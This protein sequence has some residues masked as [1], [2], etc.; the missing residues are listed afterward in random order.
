[1][2]S[3]PRSLWL[4]IGLSMAIPAPFTGCSTPPSSRVTQVQTLKA[5]GEAAEA[6][7]AASAR[8]FYA[9][10]ITSA[11]A[12]QIADIYDNKFQPAFRVAIVA[13]NANL[14]SVASPDLIAIAAQMSSLILSFQTPT[15]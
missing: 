11:Q 8:L 9:G 6:A 13:V 10:A 15:P 14:E 5:V 3:I 2:K 4:L 1:M 7:V 12:K